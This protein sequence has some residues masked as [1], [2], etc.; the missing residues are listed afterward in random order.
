MPHMSGIIQC[1][2]FYDW[3]ITLSIMSLRSI[4]IVACDNRMSFEFFF[5]KMMAQLNGFMAHDKLQIQSVFEQWVQISEIKCNIN[6]C[7][8]ASFTFQQYH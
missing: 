8:F 2:T 5:F 3:L 7:K 1:L 6:E 4:Y